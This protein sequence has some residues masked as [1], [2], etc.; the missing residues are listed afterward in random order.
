MV[1]PAPRCLSALF[2]HSISSPQL[3]YR[4]ASLASRCL[5]ARP[6]STVASQGR[7]RAGLHRPLYPG[8]I[9]QQARGFSGTS[10]RSVI[11][12]RLRDSCPGMDLYKNCS[13]SIEEQ[14]FTRRVF[15]SRLPEKGLSPP[16][17][18][19]HENA[20]LRYANN[21]IICTISEP[22]LSI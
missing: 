16:C 2:I 17:P 14:P 11:P 7:W 18:N 8:T 21:L 15:A 5:R 6:I 9:L 19:I 13:C 10:H 4:T 20:Y 3:C 1:S 12:T 22:R